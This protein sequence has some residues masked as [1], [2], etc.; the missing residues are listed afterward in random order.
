MSLFKVT[1]TKTAE[2]YVEAQ[3][4]LFAEEKVQRIL[5]NDDVYLEWQEDDCCAEFSP[6]S[7]WVNSLD[8]GYYITA[9]QFNDECHLIP[10]KI[11]DLD[12]FNE[13]DECTDLLWENDDEREL[14]IQ[15]DV[16]I[17]GSACCP[18]YTFDPEDPAWDIIN[19]NIDELLRYAELDS[20]NRFVVPNP[21]YED[22][23]DDEDDE[24]ESECLD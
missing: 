4:H 9:V 2:V 15:T 5:M 8:S 18:E 12:E 7:E 6:L 22:V 17:V 20:T 10:G 16:Y 21:Y 14:H 1:I 23:E 24:E 3:T 11:E 13:N 19:D